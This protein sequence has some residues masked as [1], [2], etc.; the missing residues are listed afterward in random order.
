MEG[1][2]DRLLHALEH[3]ITNAQEATP[4]D[5]F[6]RITL[7]MVQEASTRADELGSAGTEELKDTGSISDD[8]GDQTSL[9]CI[10]IEDDGCGMSRE[11]INTRLFAPFVTTKGNSGMGIGVFEARHVVESWGGSLEVQSTPGQGTR[12]DIYLPVDT[13]RAE[14]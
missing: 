4:D 13:E 11:F 5:G 2:S 14:A 12:F 8:R 3:L 1:D 10:T 7:Q 9:I 6:V